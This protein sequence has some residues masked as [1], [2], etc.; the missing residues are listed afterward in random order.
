M[1]TLAHYALFGSLV[2]GAAGVLVLAIVTLK[3]GVHRRIP[4]GDDPP[5]R[6]QRT[7]RSI[8]LADTVAVLC[9]AIAAGLGVVG[10]TQQTRAITAV[11]LGEENRLVERLQALEQRVERAEAQLKARAVAAEPKPWERIAQIER[12]VG[13]VEGR[14]TDGVRD[15]R[16]ERPAAAPSAASRRSSSL[17]AVPATAKREVSVMP[18]AS[19][20]SAPLS[21]DPVA[22]PPSPEATARPAPTAPAATPDPAA[23]AGPAS[24]SSGGASAVAVPPLPEPAAPLPPPPV[25]STP[26]PPAVST[27]PPPVAAV[28]SPRPRQV[29]PP[30]RP[31]PPPPAP[32]RE[33]TFG[34]RVS[35]GWDALK[36]DLERGGDEWVAGWRRLRRLFGD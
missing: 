23:S 25:V 29:A 32:A 12:R 10:L 18:S 6:S 35:S 34:E 15:R 36:R 9:F 19:P 24:A 4:D 31:A 3:Y 16:D 1:Q 33:P 27:P 26:S 7:F 21:T 2:A 5:G 20:R 11:A 28:S 30:A 17:P 8:R 13:S 22:S 14:T